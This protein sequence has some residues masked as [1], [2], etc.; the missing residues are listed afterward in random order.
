MVISS[1]IS[2]IFWRGRKQAKDLCNRRLRILYDLY[3]IDRFFPRVCRGSSQ[4][5]IVLDRAG[6]KIL[7]IDNFNKIRE[8][9]ITYKHMRLM[10]EFRVEAYLKNLGMGKREVKLS[11]IRADIYFPEYR[12]AVEIDTGS[13]SYKMLKKKA[14]KYSRTNLFAIIFV[15]DGGIKR[16]KYFLDEIKLQ[17]VKKAGCKF[18]ELGDMLRKINNNLKH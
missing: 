12:I 13:E 4:Q 5:H 6:A 18:E 8:L 7:N 9:P 11:D 3:C 16:I 2:R 15:T 17:R 14:E 1:Q 10:T